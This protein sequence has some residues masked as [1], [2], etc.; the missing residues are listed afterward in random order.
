MD[1]TLAQPN[2]NGSC[3]TDAMY[4]I[5]GASQVPIICGENSGQH[6]YVD[7]NGDAA[8]QIIIDTNSAVTLARRWNLKIAQIACDCPN[9]GKTYDQP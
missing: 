7:F 8:I 3:V 5:G 9:R 2:A 1:F 6:I 4:V